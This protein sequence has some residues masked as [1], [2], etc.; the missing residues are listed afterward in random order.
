MKE[1]FSYTEECKLINVDGMKEL[2]IIILE[3]IIQLRFRQEL[4]IIVKAI[5][6]MVDGE[7]GHL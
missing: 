7:V 4:S 1:S 6:W 3:P 2:E 5:K